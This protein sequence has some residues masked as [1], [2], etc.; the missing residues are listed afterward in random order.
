[1]AQGFAEA[2]DLGRAVELGYELANMDFTFRNI[3]RLLEE[4]QTRVQQQQDT[5]P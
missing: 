5:Q 3:G 1:M 4:W 2:G